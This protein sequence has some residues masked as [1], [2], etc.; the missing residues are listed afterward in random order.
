MAN[1]SYIPT[2][3]KS[4]PS[5]H[6]VISGGWEGAAKTVLLLLL[7]FNGHRSPCQG[8]DHLDFLLGTS[9]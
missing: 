2:A 8:V 4:N 6:D 9:F 7:L 3:I 1:P 5:M